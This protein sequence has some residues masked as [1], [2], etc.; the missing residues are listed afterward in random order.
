MTNFPVFCLLGPTASGKTAL[1]IE[2]VRT[3]PFEIISVDSAMIYKGM[4]IGTAKPMPE[5]LHQAPHRLIDIL[6]P[7]EQYSV[8]QFYTDVI[9]EIEA[10][11]AN[12]H[13]PLLVG[14]TM[15]YFYAIQQGIALMPEANAAVRIR[16]EKEAREKGWQALHAELR[17]VDPLTADKIKPTDT[18]RIQRA[19][20]IYRIS[21]IPLSE[22]QQKQARHALPYSFFNLVLQPKTRAIL[23]EKILSRF[24]Q[25]MQAGFVDEV[26][27]LYERGDLSANLP[28]MRSVGYRQ[29]WGYLEG[30]YDFSTLEQKILSATR[31]FAKRQV[32]WLNKWPNAFSLETDSQNLISKAKKYIKTPLDNI[33]I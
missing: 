25:M 32:T 31:Q 7:T 6:E 9:Q 1:A 15:M 23:H 14:G 33:I 20:E 17:Q 12:G 13:Y 30:E 16:I 8:G 18:Q 5:E 11:R 22:W 26:K 27:I 3:F 4:N 24:H 21:H 29:I 2:L 19:L 28:S 10:I